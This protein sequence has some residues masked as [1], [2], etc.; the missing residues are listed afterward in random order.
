[1]TLSK[2]IIYMVLGGLIAIGVAFAGAATF[3]Q[4]DEGISESFTISD[5]DG[6]RPQDFGRG[7]QNG[8]PNRPDR[9]EQ[10]EAFA[11]ALGITVE[12]LEAAHEEAR[13]ATIADLVAEGTITQEQADEILEGNGR[14][15]GRAPVNPEHLAE[16]LD[17]TVEDLEAAREQV[18][19]DQLEAAIEAGIITQEQADMMAAHRAVQS[20]VDQEAIQEAIRAEHESAINQA[21]DAGEIN[22]EQAD[23]MLNNL[24]N[25]DG[26]GFGFGNNGRQGHRG[27]GPHGNGPQNAPPFQ[28]EQPDNSN[29]A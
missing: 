12:E 10:A 15:G 25:L 4:E 18:R 2:K 5:G 20:Y 7:G 17:I 21:L 1:M 24:E 26:R 8:R 3:A 6:E 9:G 16:A 11:N 23:E 29:D 27:H 28:G 13:A 14:R 22:Q 19:A